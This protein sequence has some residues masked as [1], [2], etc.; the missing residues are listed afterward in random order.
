MNKEMETYEASGQRRAQ[1]T[2]NNDGSTSFWTA[3]GRD[4]GPYNYCTA[5]ELEMFAECYTLLTT[6]DCDSKEA[7]LTYFPETL[8]AV[9]KQL[10]EIRALPERQR[11]RA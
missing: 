7:I 11:H 10:A 8:K 4:E 9:E 1:I 2:Y 6:G 5:T 3:N